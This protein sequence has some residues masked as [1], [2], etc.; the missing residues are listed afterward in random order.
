MPLSNCI[1][2]VHLDSR[3]VSLMTYLHFSHFLIVFKY[4]CVC[5]QVNKEDHLP[6]LLCSAAKTALAGDK[7][8]KDEGQDEDQEANAWAAGQ[9]PE[10]LNLVAEELKCDVKDVV[11]FELTLFDTQVIFKVMS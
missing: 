8:K 6:P 4:V 10:L 2:F 11:D 5:L 9:E 1:I 3:I 7:D